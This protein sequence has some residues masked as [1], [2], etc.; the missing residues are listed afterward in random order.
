MRLLLSWTL[1]IARSETFAYTEKKSLFLTCEQDGIRPFL[2]EFL[3]TIIV[4]NPS[5][6]LS[7][8][9]TPHLRRWGFSHI[10]HW[11]NFV[12]V[13]PLR[14]FSVLFKPRWHLI[15]HAWNT[16]FNSATLLQLRLRH[17]HNAR[18]I[19]RRYLRVEAKRKIFECC[20]DNL[21]GLFPE[22]QNPRAALTKF[23]FWAIWH[24]R[25]L[26]CQISVSHSDYRSSW[27]IWL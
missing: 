19:D 1:S 6:W 20:Q 22:I 27:N 11:A 24:R 21:S 16:A 14:Q 15:H 7:R 8:D 12:S 17:S 25:T 10:V 5:W 3:R 4:H 23:G 2:L 9:T 18:S 13:G 26:L